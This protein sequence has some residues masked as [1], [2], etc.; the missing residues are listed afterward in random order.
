ML[1]HKLHPRVLAFTTGRNEDLSLKDSDDVV[2]TDTIPQQ[3]RE[4]LGWG[5]DGF[6]PLALPRQTHSSHVVWASAPG[7]EPE[8]DAVITDV[9]GLCVCVKTAD[10]IPVLLYDRV[11]NVVAS[12][13]AGWKGTVRYIVRNT[14]DMMVR[15]GTNPDDVVAVIA[16]GIS[17]DSFEVGDEVYG[18]FLQSGFPVDRIARRY[19]SNTPEQSGIACRWHI[20]LWEANR[21]V[22]EQCGVREIS[23]SGI[24]TYTSPEYYSARRDTIDTGRNFNGILILP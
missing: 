17:I 11:R 2:A 15:R 9:P 10:C 4:D 14:I 3:L 19:P 18:R 21:W 5:I 16:P 20:D 13:H 8:T 23:I 24:D 7:R 1:I 12:V 22:L 6:L